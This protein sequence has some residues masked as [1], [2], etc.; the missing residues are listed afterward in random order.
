M[1]EVLRPSRPWV[2]IDGS[3]VLRNNSRGDAH[4]RGSA[5]TRSYGIALRRAV[6]APGSAANRTRDLTASL[7]LPETDEN[8]LEGMRVRARFNGPGGHG[9]W[10]GVF[11][12]RFGPGSGST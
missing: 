1:L 6:L 2:E 4:A 8:D 7:V 3:L 11:A 9:P 12:L 5:T 10:S